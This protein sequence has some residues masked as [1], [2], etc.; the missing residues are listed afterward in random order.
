MSPKPRKPKRKTPSKKSTFAEV[1][2]PRIRGRFLPD[3]PAI[4]SNFAFLRLAGGTKIIGR[5]ES[6]E[7]INPRNWVGRIQ[8]IQGRTKTRIIKRIVSRFGKKSVVLF[9]KPFVRVPGKDPKTE[10]KNLIKAEERGVKVERPLGF[11]EL[12]SGEGFIVTKMVEGITLSKARLSRLSKQQR[13]KILK[14]L[15]RWLAT[16]HNRGVFHNDLHF[17]NILVNPKELQAKRKPVEPILIDFTESRIGKNV[18]EQEFLK[19]LRNL[20]VECYNYGLISLTWREVEEIG[21]TYLR[22]RGFT[23]RKALNSLEL[24][25]TFLKYGV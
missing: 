22:F 1:N 18:R 4:H 21:L 12:P 10:F 9:L 25:K 24:L 14:D 7:F 23:G 3:S 13:K 5:I 19:D 17:E 16:L 8:T 2:P 11:V 6:F 15:V 20:I